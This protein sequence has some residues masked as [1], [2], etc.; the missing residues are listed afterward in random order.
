MAVQTGPISYFPVHFGGAISQTLVGV[1]KEAIRASQALRRHRARARVAFYIA[2]LT[3]IVCRV[4][5]FTYWTE[6][7]A[8]SFI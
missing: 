5:V 2:G 4:A 8:L 3:D 6:A 7:R 1:Q